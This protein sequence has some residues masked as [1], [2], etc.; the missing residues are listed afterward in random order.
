LFLRKV[1]EKRYVA[2]VIAAKTKVHGKK[3]PGNL[4]K[5]R[6]NFIGFK[7]I[8]LGGFMLIVPNGFQWPL[9]SLVPKS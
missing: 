7:N 6:K 2:T 3:I 5:Y 9:L 8:S 1:L 4:K